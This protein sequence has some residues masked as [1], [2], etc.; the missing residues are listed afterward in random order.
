MGD[1]EHLSTYDRLLE[2]I[3]SGVYPPGAR[4]V[5][6]T[7]AE[8][9][10][11]SVVPV[12]EALGRL[13]SEGLV[14]HIPGAGSF[15]RALDNRE[16][17]K[18][19]ALREHLET[20]AVVE[21][22]KNAQGYHIQQLQRCCETSADILKRL[23][24]SADARVRSQLVEDWV[25]SDAAFHSAIIEAADNTWLGMAAERLRVL[26][27]VARAKPRDLDRG[28]YE[29][30]LREHAAITKAIEERNAGKAEALMRKHIQRAMNAV[31]MGTYERS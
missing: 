13:T 29:N 28:T 11:V 2:K 4:L 19:Y 12:R 16:L 22:A 1:S 26:A 5:N 20:F 21:A 8:D 23:Q 6:R 7:V 27:H 31:L 18:L 9:L 3:L 10:G 25:A 17:A 14:A 30:A 15:V 24:K